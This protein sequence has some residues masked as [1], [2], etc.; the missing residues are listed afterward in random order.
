MAP[1]L[2]VHY[3]SV[4]IVHLCPVNVVMSQPI[5]QREGK[6]PDDRQVG[7][8]GSDNQDHKSKKQVFQAVGDTL[9]VSIDGF[10][11]NLIHGLS[12]KVNVLVFELKKNKYA[13]GDS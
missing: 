11:T 8:R 6:T 13:Q 5:K 9:W 1:E 10:S 4:A 3:I 12:H 7:E 2:F